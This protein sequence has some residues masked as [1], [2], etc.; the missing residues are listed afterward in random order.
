MKRISFTLLF[1]FFFNIQSSDAALSLKNILNHCLENNFGIKLSAITQEEK[2]ASLIKA[3]GEYDWTL[4]LNFKIDRKITPSSSKL[5]GV[6]QEIGLK[7]RDTTSSLSLQKKTLLGTKLELPFRYSIS[8]TN[9][10]Q[11]LFN[12]SYAGNLTLKATQPILKTFTPSYFWKEIDKANLDLEIAQKEN[13]QKLIETLSKTVSIY[14]ETLQSEENLNIK[15]ASYK[16]A[17]LNYEYVSEKTKFG[18]ASRLDLLEAESNKE[19]LFEG[20]IKAETDLKNKKAELALQTFAD[21]QKEIELEKDIES[22]IMPM[23]PQ[24]NLEETVKKALETRL[25][26][27]KNKDSLLKA[28]LEVKTAYVDQ[29]PQLNLDAD[30]TLNGLSGAPGT[31][32]SQLRQR[33]FLSWSSALTLEHPLMMYASRS[34]SQI[35]NLRL[36]QEKIKKTQI[37]QDIVSEI[38]E[39]FRNL[40]ASWQRTKAL[41]KASEAESAR[42][43]GQSELYRLGK[44]SNYELNKSLEDKSR[45]QLELLESKINYQKSVY[46]LSEK[47]GTLLEELL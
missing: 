17:T 20:V 18:K 35:K 38:K 47:K 31:T 12:P 2:A 19:K 1:V 24:I 15:K 3:Y 7:T 34:A 27:Q 14:Y 28:E 10:S 5:D 9:S 32:F 8:E 43:E 29:L 23:E 33:E 22:L 46:Q 39:A 36:E 44:I 45:S 26:Y 13:K 41:T 16:T 6:D 11:K 4:K 40:Q 21:S 25:E 30:I 37:E 42:Y